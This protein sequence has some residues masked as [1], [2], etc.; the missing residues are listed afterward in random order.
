MFESIKNKNV[1]VTGGSSGIGNAVC[2]KLAAYGMN[3]FSTYHKTS[4]NNESLN[5]EKVGESGTIYRYHLDVSNVDMVRSVV[6]E[7]ESKHGYVSYLVNCAGINKD[8]YMLMMDKNDWDSVLETDLTGTFN[9]IQAVLTSMIFNHQGSIVNISSIAGLTG[10]AGQ[11]NYCAAK[12][13][14]IG[15]TKALAK[16]VASKNIRVN[17]IAPGYIETRMIESV[18]KKKEFVNAIP[19]KKIGTCEDIANTVLFLL[20]DGAQYITGSTIVVDGGVSA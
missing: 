1:I 10:V 11:V 3:V 19:M 15:L 2:L 14:V 13:G 17:A 8:D 6:D 7:I 18:K 20:S 9:T 16:E 5:G 12:A 4:V